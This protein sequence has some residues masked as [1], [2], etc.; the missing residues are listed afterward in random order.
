MGEVW[1]AD[2]LQLNQP[3]AL[4]FLPPELSTDPVA[5]SRLLAEVRVARQVS[6]PSVCRVYDVSQHNGEQFI[7]ME[8]IDGEDLASVLRRIGRPDREKSVEIARQLCAALQ[9]AHDL[10]VLHRDL[11]PGNVMLDGRGRARL[12]DFGLAGAADHLR[13]GGHHG[14]TPAYMAPEQ[15]ERGEVSVQSDIYSLGLILYELFT[16]RP[17]F[18]AKTLEE[19]RVQRRSGLVQSVS[20]L[21]EN[22]DPAIE[23]VIEHCLAPDPR[24]RPPSAI[25]VAAALPGGD[26]LAAALAAGEMPS[27]ELV[28]AAGPSGLLAPRVAVGLLAVTLLSLLIHLFF[29]PRRY[30]VNHVPLPRNMAVMSDRATEMATALGYLP[31]RVIA[32]G[33]S[34]DTE[35]LAHLD[36]SSSDRSRFVALRHPAPAAI[37]FWQ[38]QARAPMIPGIW[39]A[40]LEP[41]SRFNPPLDQ[42]NML[43]LET[44]TDGKLLA[45]RWVPP[46]TDPAPT[47]TNPAGTQSAD[48]G[49]RHEAEEL[50]ALIPL[51][52]LDPESLVAVEPTR[53]PPVPFDQRLAF[54]GKFAGSG[55]EARFEAGSYRGRPTFVEVNGVWPTP[56]GP[57]V[58]A[59]LMPAALAVLVGIG[60][61]GLVYLHMHQRRAD[62]LRAFR[63][64][65]IAFSLTLLLCF[66]GTLPSGAAGATLG[67]QI[68]PALAFSL[69]NGGFGWA[70]YVALEPYIRRRSP[71]RLVSLTRLLDWRLGDPLIWRDVLIGFACSASALLLVNGAIG[72][73]ARLNP[74]APAATG[75]G[76]LQHGSDVL[77]HIFG[78]LTGAIYGAMTFT[79]LPLLFR[80]ILRSQRAAVVAVC[81]LVAA[82]I[83]VNNANQ[84]PL[85]IIASIIAWG[86]TLMAIFRYGV[87]AG[88][89]AVFFVNVLSTPQVSNDLSAWYATPAMIVVGL[90]SALAILACYRS[91]GNQRI[92]TDPLL[93]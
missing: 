65:L 83:T 80:I 66:L 84:T 41:L 3:V 68:V 22:I 49:T 57:G 24:Q 78:T 53:A 71:H 12:M 39:G 40:A 60:A 27:P 21:A 44:T 2:D 36:A 26:P 16:G 46:R 89:A 28:A 10:R 92:L 8:Y 11:K 9:A 72:L 91:I 37:R 33:L 67:A 62:T 77:R 34:A 50:H 73:D 5:L 18:N 1:R 85:S 88:I 63:I 75:I 70:L 13:G 56:P 74:A 30:L 20:S 58:L 59:S 42:P 29:N 47:T 79:F 51:T 38:R 19:L 55:A 90:L 15:F 69:F 76:L 4:K 54:K 23:R 32:S 17:A 48:T 45:L 61:S 86:V 64:G 87:V 7:S 82:F 81:L 35:Y 52:P 25:A 31:Q 43:L 14:G 6:H 93:P